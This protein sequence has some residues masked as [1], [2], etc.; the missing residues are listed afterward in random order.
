VRDTAV[1]GAGDGAEAFLSGSIPDLKFAHFS[2]NLCHFEA[3]VD[4]DGG[5]VVVDEVVVAESDEEGGLADSLVAHNH[6]LEEEILLFDHYYHR[7]YT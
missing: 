1:V 3:E 6:Y 7:V 5:Q 2:F 4:S